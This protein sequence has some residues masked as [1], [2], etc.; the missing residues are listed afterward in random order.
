M[1]ERKTLNTTVM[2]E[3][4]RLSL[5]AL[6]ACNWVQH[7]LMSWLKGFV[8]LLMWSG[9]SE[10]GYFKKSMTNSTGWEFVTYHCPL[11]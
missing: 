3:V 4:R 7:S 8:D 10:G 5:V 6:S 9:G 11:G 1:C 2:E